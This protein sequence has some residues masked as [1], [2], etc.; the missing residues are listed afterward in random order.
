MTTPFSALDH[1]HMANALRLA[2]RA[3]YTTRP[4]PMV[5]CVIAHGERVVGQGWHEIA[6]QGHAEVN[7]L[8]VAGAAARGATAYVSLEPCSHHGKTPPCADAVAAAG[9]KKVVI[10]IRDANPLVAGDGIRI[11]EK[12]GIEVK[13][14]LR[15]EDARL[16]YEGFFF[17]I[18]HG[19]PKVHVKIAQSLDGRALAI[20][21]DR[22]DYSQGLAERFRAW[23]VLLDR[24]PQLHRAITYLQI[25]SP[26]REGVPEYRR[27]R[28]ELEGLAGSING[29]HAAPDWTALRYVPR[30]YAAATL[31]GFYRLARAGLVTPLR[32]GMNLVAKEYVAAQAADDPGVLVL[33]RFAGAARELE[34]ALLVNPYDVEGMA[35]TFAAALAMP[36]DERIERWRALHAAVLRHT[37]QSW[38]DG[39]LEALEAPTWTTMSSPALA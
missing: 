20:G 26:I 29:A 18:R 9:V 38:C 32:D 6:G 10:A 19:R 25:A 1:L 22:L 8:R 14:G 4:N 39:F 35:E 34:G 27:V 33:S 5:G 2:V 7:A 30:R 13:V 15:E 24:A 31:A 23:G 3:A 16:F 12:A 28:R 36:R 21:V 37:A 11:L 17:F